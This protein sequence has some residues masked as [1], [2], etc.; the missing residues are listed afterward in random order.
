MGRPAALSVGVGSAA[1][2]LI[3]RGTAGGSLRRG[4]GVQRRGLGSGGL[5]RF[6]GADDGAV[7]A[8]RG[9]V[10][11]LDAGVD[12]AGIGQPVQVLGSGQGAGDATDVTATFGPVGWR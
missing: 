5:G 6:D 7:Q 2:R 8:G 3:G 4:G 1:G 12:E 10:G 9:F 11:E